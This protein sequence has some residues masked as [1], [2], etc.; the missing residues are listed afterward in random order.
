ME[1]LYQ[2]LYEKAID[3]FIIKKDIISLESKKQDQST[4]SLGLFYFEEFVRLKQSIDLSNS[5][6]CDHF[7]M[8]SYFDIE[9]IQDSDHIFFLD[10]IFYLDDKI[11]LDLFNNMIPIEL[12]VNL[13]SKW[14]KSDNN[15]YIRN[16]IF[17]DIFEEISD[18]AIYLYLKFHTLKNKINES[19][20]N[21]INKEV[22]KSHPYKVTAL[23]K[24]NFLK[25]Y[26]FIEKLENDYS[27][28]GH[29]T[30]SK[31]LQFLISENYTT[32]RRILNASKSEDTD[33]NDPSRKKVDKNVDELIDK[34]LKK[35]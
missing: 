25:R 13:K 10:D 28:N 18:Q 30:L 32:I 20:K 19:D 11:V 29:D 24:I 35:L 14:P 21:K 26:G 1:Y 6:F 34:I 17:Q 5:I 12:K 16:S 33:K 27:K 3:K 22:D 23:M 8:K 9:L 2:Y 4:H 15:K 31:I 7:L